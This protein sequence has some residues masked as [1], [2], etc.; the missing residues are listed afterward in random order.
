LSGC[1]HCPAVAEMAYKV[2]SQ[3]DNVDVAIVNIPTPEGN[4][5]ARKLDLMS[6]LTI[7]INGKVAFIG[8]S[9]RDMIMHDAVRKVM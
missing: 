8:T 6:V 9:Q 7:A 2:A 3:Y 1:C 5:K 4:S